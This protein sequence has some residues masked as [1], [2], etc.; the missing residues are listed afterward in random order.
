MWLGTMS[1]STSRP[2]PA[3]CAEGRLAAEVRGD[4]ARVDDVVAVGRAAPGLERGG[5]VEVAHAE[6]AQVRHQPEGVGEPHAGA[7]LEPV[8]RP[9]QARR[10]S[11]I[12]RASRGTSARAGQVF[13]PSGASGSAVETTWRHRLPNRRAGSRKPVGS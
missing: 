9:H 8:G 3:S 6:L 4:P 1:S 2:A 12:D 13:A 7:E 5:E 11:R 10:M